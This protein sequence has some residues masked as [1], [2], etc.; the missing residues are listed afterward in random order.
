MALLAEAGCCCP[1]LQSAEQQAALRGWVER[2]SMQHSHKS[3]MLLSRQ[4][5][6][7]AMAAF[8]PVAARRGSELAVELWLPTAHHTEAT[9]LLPLPLAQNG[10][11]SNVVG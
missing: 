3:L 8:D 6:H 1:D 5:F 7:Q 4:L 11:N 10:D 9:A 2:T